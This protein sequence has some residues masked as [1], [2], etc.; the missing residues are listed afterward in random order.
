MI[1][2]LKCDLLIY[3][4]EFRDIYRPFKID[5]FQF[6]PSHD[7]VNLLKGYEED[8]VR[9]V[10]ERD[11]KYACY[12]QDT[13]SDEGFFGFHDNYHENIQRLITAFR[14]LK[15]G[16]IQVDS[17]MTKIRAKGIKVIKDLN[18][19]PNEQLWADPLNYELWE[20]ELPLIKSLFNKLKN[21]P[22]GY[23]DVAIK[24]FNRSYDYYTKDEID[25]CFA[26]LVIA[27]ESLTSRG[28]DGILQS[29]KLR[30]SLFLRNKYIDRKKLEKDIGTYYDHRSN[31]LH[32][33]KINQKKR[34]ERADLLENLRDL[35]R[36]TI[37][38][39]VELLETTC[40]REKTVAETIDAYLYKK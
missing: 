11:V 34:E 39:C 24:R 27:L 29:M 19:P 32:G 37:V 38:G 22:P 15:A 8:H 28:G 25:D 3:N 7:L 17:I 14:L 5:R 6:Y 21:M 2:K 1:R 20:K 26:D 18:P 33:G 9:W 36:N 40:N 30:I 35:V 23:L 4:L 12:R 10:L 31:I 16:W 13:E